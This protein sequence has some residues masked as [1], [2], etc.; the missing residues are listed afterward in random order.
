MP[1]RAVLPN[2]FL[3]VELVSSKRSF[4]GLDRLLSKSISS[5]MFDPNVCETRSR[6]RPQTTHLLHKLIQGW[7][8]VRTEDHISVCPQLPEIP[9]NLF[10]HPLNGA[11]LEKKATNATMSFV[12]SPRPTSTT[13]CYSPTPSRIKHQS[14][15]TSEVPMISIRPSGWWGH[16]CPQPARHSSHKSWKD[17]W[18]MR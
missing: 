13:T 6:A 12:Y 5:D 3:K 10:A 8:L 18:D 2:P 4:E 14:V 1:T 11:S 16:S 17:R 9:G 15:W 7:F